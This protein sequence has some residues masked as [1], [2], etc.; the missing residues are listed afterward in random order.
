MKIW[1]QNHRYKLKKAGQE[2]GTLDPGSGTTSVL[3]VGALPPATSP[4]R[5]SIPV[6]VRDGKPCHVVPYEQSA[7]SEP[8]RVMSSASDYRYY[9]LSSTAGYDDSPSTE[10]F[11]VRPYGTQPACA[12]VVYHPPHGGTTDPHAFHSVPAAAASASVNSVMTHLSGTS[13]SASTLPTAAG[14][15]CTRTCTVTSD[16]VTTAP[17]AACY[18]QSRWW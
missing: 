3:H 15:H 13:A 7:A 1:F 4:R 5:V 12:A 11:G 6:L 16:P 18:G 17:A 9:S 8:Y 10:T 14:D 2:K